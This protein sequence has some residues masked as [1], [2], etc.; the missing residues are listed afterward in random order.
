MSRR[1]RL[2]FDAYTVTGS[3]W[4]V[5]VCASRQAGPVFADPA[6]ARL[7]LDAFEN[8]CRFYQAIL[9][10][11]CVMPDHVHLLVE[12]RNV[13]LVELIGRVKSFSMTQWWKQGNQGMLWQESFYDHGIRGS[14][15]FD[16]TMTYILNNPVSAELVSE[17]EVYPFIAGTLIR[18]DDGSVIDGL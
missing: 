7:I 1:Q 5:T 9:H 11:V 8:G 4:H 14:R 12:I 10:V 18:E 2:P 17:W 16:A 15:D 3:V 13:G 6:S